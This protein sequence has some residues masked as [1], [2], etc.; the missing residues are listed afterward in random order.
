MPDGDSE[1]NDESGL[2]LPAVKA[3]TDVMNSKPMTALLGPAFSAFGR[4]WGERAEEMVE[5]WNEKRQRNMADHVQRVADAGV[6]PPEKPTENQ[7]KQ[8]AEWAAGASEVDPEEEPELAALWQSVLERINRSDRDSEKLLN[9]LREIEPED[10]EYL[11]R[12]AG[13]HTWRANDEDQIVFDR[14]IA[15][16]LLEKVR[17]LYYRPHGIV[18]YLLSIA[19]ITMLWL[20]IS[21]SFDL[22][23]FTGFP[24]S[25]ELLASTFL[26][27]AG[28][29]VTAAGAVAA[30]WGTARLSRLGRQ[31]V[32]SGQ[33]YLRVAEGGSKT[34]AN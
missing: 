30:Y 16:G 6:P 8:Q 5:R 27:L 7:F 18:V 28:F 11:L 23:P 26:L 10:A 32:E 3:A 21:L 31:L 34:D 13:R 4:Y 29:S 22:P 9:V 17:F 19:C 33:R 1:K 12:R 15:A 24:V 14:L 20:F 2:N 25:R